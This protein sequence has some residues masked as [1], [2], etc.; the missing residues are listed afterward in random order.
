MLDYGGR[1]GGG[2]MCSFD[3]IQLIHFIFSFVL[4]KL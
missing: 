2:G 3:Q 1:G 4:I